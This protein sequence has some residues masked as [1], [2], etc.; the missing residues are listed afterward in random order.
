MINTA[1]LPYV[2]FLLFSVVFWIGAIYATILIIRYFKRM[3]EAQELIQN[4]LLE[5]AEELRRRP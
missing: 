1:M 5:I 4:A 2:S 3:A